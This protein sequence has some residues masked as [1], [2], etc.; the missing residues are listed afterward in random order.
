MVEYLYHNNLLPAI[1][2]VFSRKQCYVWANLVN[3][4]LF[5]EGSLIP[6]I[7]EKKATQILISKLPNW[8]E[9]VELPEFKSIVKLLEKG[10]KVKVTHD[11]SS[12][13]YQ[14]KFLEGT[15]SI[16]LD[17][18]N[19]IAYCSISKRS[20]EELFKK[21]CND[22]NFYPIV[23]NSIYESKPI[24]H[25]NVLM[26]ICNKF[27]IICLKSIKDHKE[28]NSI[29]NSLENSEL[30]IIDISIDQL[31]SYLGNCI[32]LID[33]ESNPKLV[34]STSAFKS[35]NSNHLINHRP[36]FS[37]EIICHSFALFNVETFLLDSGSI[38]WIH[39]M[40]KAIKFGQ[41]QFLG[42]T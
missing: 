15:G 38:S 24:Y 29:I 40:Y 26:S 4:S 2:F 37:P 10:I 5:E 14:N 27:C 30:E 25:T 39:E 8:K 19:K 42:A 18:K 13:E 35:I 23:F 28:K 7:I 3:K 16:V 9:Y 36:I 33:K 1:A 20:N 34:M 21:F 32:Q 17:R 22:L 31:R 11:Y 12:F 6:S 41:I